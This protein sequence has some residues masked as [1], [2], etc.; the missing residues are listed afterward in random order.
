VKPGNIVGA[1]ANEAGLDGEHIGQIDISDSYTLVDLPKGMPNEIF[2]DLAKT[3]V[4]G[5]ALKITKFGKGGDTQGGGGKSA[6][7]SSD[8]KPASGKRPSGQPGGKK[9]SDGKGFGGGK[10]AGKKPGGPK[11]SAGKKPAAG[12]KRGPKPGGKKA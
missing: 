5:Q 3:R 2:K 8:R 9:R 1:I 6:D 11:R 7:R 12:A 10:S 4:C